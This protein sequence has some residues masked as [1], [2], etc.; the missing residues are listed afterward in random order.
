MRLLFCSCLCLLECVLVWGGE[1]R[2]ESGGGEERGETGVKANG[3]GG[4]GV[5]V[6]DNERICLFLSLS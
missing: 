5:V 2:G 6:M 1:G 4:R 3:I